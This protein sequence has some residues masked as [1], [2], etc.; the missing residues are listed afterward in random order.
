MQD[1]LGA[2]RCSAPTRAV[3]V[4]ARIMSRPGV[5]STTSEHVGRA[6]HYEHHRGHSL[7]GNVIRAHWR[8]A[9]VMVAMS[10]SSAVFL[11]YISPANAS[12]TTYKA[13][14]VRF[15]AS[16][17]SRVTTT[18]VP[19]A[20]L[21]KAFSGVR[22]VTAATVFSAG[23]NANEL[24]SSSAVPEPDAFEVTVITF[25]STSASNNLFQ[26]YA[27]APGAEKETVDGRR[28]YDAIGNAAKLNSGTTVPDKNATQ[29]DLAVLDG[30]SILVA[31]VETKK[32][33]ATK[34]FLLSVK[35]LS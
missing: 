13:G 26:G 25:S 7:G 32:T 31:L 14:S 20:E 33:S 22:G 2:Q 12:T 28:A 6:L 3:F 4:P 9:A 17:P 30:K 24:F 8:R 15:Q 18:P 11:A 1:H 10:V 23:V 19:K 16:F 5:D 29:G 27:S 34:S 21:A 35:I